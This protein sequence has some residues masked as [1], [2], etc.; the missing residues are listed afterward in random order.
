MPRPRR[1]PPAMAEIV[2]EW[3][4]SDVDIGTEVAIRGTLRDSN[5]SGVLLMTRKE[6]HWE[7]RGRWTTSHLSREYVSGERLSAILEKWVP[8]DFKSADASILTDPDEARALWAGFEDG[9]IRW[10]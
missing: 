4:P 9:A 6:N 8:H 5:L 1:P 7:Q 2:E 10:R 3:D